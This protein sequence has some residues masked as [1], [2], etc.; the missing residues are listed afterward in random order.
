METP[1]YLVTTKN[2]FMPFL[3]F[4]YDKEN[5]WQDNIGMTVYDLFQRKYTENG[6]QWK[7][8]DVDHL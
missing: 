6:K 7:N 5:H 3:T 8:I 4:T 2:T 1:R